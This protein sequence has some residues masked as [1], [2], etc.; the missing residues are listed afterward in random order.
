MKA[1]S[2]SGNKKTIQKENVTTNKL[3]Y[4]VW[5]F[6]L[7]AVGIFLFAALVFNAGGI[8]GENIALLHI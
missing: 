1:V 2:K 8:V 5:G 4:E 7:I 3:L 6:V